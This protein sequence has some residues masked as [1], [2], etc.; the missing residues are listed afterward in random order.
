L[1]QEDLFGFVSELTMP[2]GTRDIAAA[3]LL[4][5]LVSAKGRDWT[6]LHWVTGGLS[7][8][9]LR[10]PLIELTTSRWFRLASFYWSARQ[11]IRKVVGS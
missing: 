7:P 10:R 11:A 3:R 9:F 1:I 8:L 6:A 4:L 2:D 5:E